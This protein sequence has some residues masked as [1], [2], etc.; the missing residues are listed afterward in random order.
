MWWELFQY[1]GTCVQAALVDIQGQVRKDHAWSFGG[2]LVGADVVAFRASFF[3][4]PRGG[5][6]ERRVAR[7]RLWVR[8]GWV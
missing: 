4:S 6:G 8:A 3:S 7:E 5:C 2:E 1:K